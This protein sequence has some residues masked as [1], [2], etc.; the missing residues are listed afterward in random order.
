MTGTTPE[1]PA[2]EPPTALSDPAPCSRHLSASNLIEMLSAPSPSRVQSL[3]SPDAQEKPPPASICPLLLAGEIHSIPSHLPPPS[4]FP[5]MRPGGLLKVMESAQVWPGRA[6]LWGERPLGKGRWAGVQA[7]RKS[8]PEAGE[9]A[10]PGVSGSGSVTRGRV[11]AAQPCT[12]GNKEEVLALAPIS[13]LASEAPVCL[14]EAKKKCGTGNK[15]RCQAGRNQSSST[16]TM[17]PLP[18]GLS[19]FW[20][21]SDVTVASLSP[22]STARVT[23]PHHLQNEVWVLPH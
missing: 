1:Q 2:R 19:G 16:F 12:E 9:A 10:D 14:L 21:L 8:V 17:H 6:G 20:P 7:G 3:I 4:H 11:P 18:T 23:V 22:T 15:T 13:S 5:R